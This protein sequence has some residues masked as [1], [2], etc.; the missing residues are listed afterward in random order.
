MAFVQINKVIRHYVIHF[1]AYIRWYI[2]G[3]YLKCMIHHYVIHPMILFS[4]E[5]ATHSHNIAKEK[6]GSLTFYLRLDP[7]KDYRGYNFRQQ[8]AV[9]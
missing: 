6:I 4:L 2:T 7:F 8:M 9:L 3:F 1:F 5:L